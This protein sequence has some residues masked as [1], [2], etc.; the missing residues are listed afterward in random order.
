MKSRNFGTIFLGTLLVILAVSPIAFGSVHPWSY[1]AESSVIFLLFALWLWTAKKKG[2]ITVVST[3]IVW[4]LPLAILFFIIQAVPLPLSFVRSISPGRAAVDAAAGLPVAGGA[5]VIS[6]RTETIA[7]YPWGVEQQAFILTATLL[8]FLFVINLVRKRE[9][10]EKALTAFYVIGLILAVFAI[11]QRMAI[12]SPSFLP[13][14]NKNHFAGYMELLVPLAVSSLAY[15]IGK[16]DKEESLK[17]TIIKV[18]SSSSGSK[19]IFFLFLTVLFSACVVLTYSRGGMCGMIF[20]LAVLAVILGRNKK[21]AVA[22]AVCC[23]AVIFLVL[24]ADEGKISGHVENFVDTAV[25]RTQIWGDTVKMIKAFPVS[26]VGL[27]GFETA[28]PYF[29]TNKIQMDFFQPESDYLYL[30]AEGGVIG[31]SLAAAFVFIYF[32]ETWGKFRKRRDPFSRSVYAG[33]VSGLAGLL[34]HGFV[35]TSLHMPA[36]L[37]ACSAL[38]ALGYVSVSVRFR[39]ASNSE[40]KSYLREK[41]YNLRSFPA[42]AFVAVSIVLALAVS[43]VSMASA[44]ADLMYRSGLNLK[45]RLA[46]NRF[47]TADDYLDLRN[48]FLT[49]SELNPLCAQYK[50][51]QGRAEEWLAEYYSVKEGLEGN[52]GGKSREFYLMALGS[53][54]GSLDS[55]PYSSFEHLVAGELLRRGFGDR[56]GQ[57]REYQAALMLNPTNRF[58]QEQVRP[59]GKQPAL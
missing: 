39:Y 5:G 44:G 6:Y 54:N 9:Q 42:R 1:G 10:V 2:R 48:R 34:L 15:Q 57:D 46:F 3:V 43:A 27:G 29:K 19:V 32:F 25:F 53:F 21:I 12:D 55:N 58:I 56:D 59:L 50:F 13:F 49:A 7:L 41:K 45:S 14:I 30:L 31:F 47:V 11:V 33:A 22:T 4:L 51:E 28:F 38:L 26:G 23:A 52:K 24:S 18:F 35:D 37:F 8:I 16:I 17:E 40:N 36:I 20:S